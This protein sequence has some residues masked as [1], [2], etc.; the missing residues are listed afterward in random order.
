[1]SEYC[2]LKAMFLCLYFVWNTQKEN[3]LLNKI[4]VVAQRH[5]G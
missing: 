1:M 5:T 3:H 2:R 4:S